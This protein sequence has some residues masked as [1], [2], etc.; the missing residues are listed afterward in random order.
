MCLYITH[1]FNYLR[2]TLHLPSTKFWSGQVGSVRAKTL[3]PRGVC[4]HA[5]PPKI[6]KLEIASE[7]I[8]GPM[9]C[10]SDRGQMTELHMNAILPIAL[11]TNGVGFRSSSL[12]G[13]KPHPS[14]V[15]LARLAIVHLQERKVVGRL[16]EQ[17]CRTVRSYLAS[18]NMVPVCFGALHGRP[19]CNGANWQCQASHE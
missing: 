18:F 1:E 14:Q 9:R 7:T 6:L 13:R 10:F 12:I 8:F 4:G 3:Y 5:S 11:Y 2:Y 17:F 16:A 19:P 15:K